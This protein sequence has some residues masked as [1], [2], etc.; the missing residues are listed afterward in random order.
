MDIDNLKT[1]K[2][3]V[4]NSATEIVSANY[5]RQ[6]LIIYNI[7]AQDIYID[8]ESSECTV[9]SFPVKAGGYIKFGNFQGSLYGITAS[10]SSEVRVIYT[11]Y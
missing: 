7:G 8:N 4:T 1:D 11:Q 2:V 3:S 5:K 9:D 6:E 10:G